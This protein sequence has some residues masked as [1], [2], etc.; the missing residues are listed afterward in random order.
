[1]QKEHERRNTSCLLLSTSSLWKKKYVFSP[2][3]WLYKN[4]FQCYFSHCWKKDS[5][6]P[7]GPNGP[8]EGI[9]ARHLAVRLS[10]EERTAWAANGT[11]QPCPPRTV[12]HR[13]RCQDVAS[14]PASPTGTAR[15]PRIRRGRNATPCKVRASTLPGLPAALPGGGSGDALIGAEDR[16]RARWPCA[17]STQGAA[18]CPPVQSLGS[19]DHDT[20][21]DPHLHWKHCPGGPMP[22]RDESRAACWRTVLSSAAIGCSE[23]TWESIALAMTQIHLENQ[24]E[25]LQ[26]SFL[27]PRFLL[28]RKKCIWSSNVTISK[29]VWALYPS[30]ICP[31]MWFGRS[32]YAVHLFYILKFCYFV[33]NDSNM[34]VGIWMCCILSI[35]L[36]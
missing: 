30:Q 6:P 5:S 3:Q 32:L 12:L 15:R 4:W 27:T 29:I 25:A 8:S 10:G 13:R 28:W 17:T 22:A 7:W 36:S 24:L 16:H 26:F 31:L 19:A 33:F 1:M 18:T 14:P 23:K 11:G 21:G 20:R 9:A 34:M 2:Q 35:A